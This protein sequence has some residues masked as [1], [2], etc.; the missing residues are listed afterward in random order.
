MD[1]A[2]RFK[3]PNTVQELWSYLARQE[4]EEIQVFRKNNSPFQIGLNLDMKKNRRPVVPF[5]SSEF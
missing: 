5:R 2:W 1:N 4:P 3:S